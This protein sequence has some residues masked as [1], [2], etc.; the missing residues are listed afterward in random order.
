MQRQLTFSRRFL[1]GCRRLAS[2]KT[3]HTKR[4]AREARLLIPFFFFLL[5][6]SQIITALIGGRQKPGDLWPGS[7]VQKMNLL[8]GQ[9]LPNSWNFVSVRR[10]LTGKKSSNPPH[11]LKFRGFPLSLSATRTPI[12]E[13]LPVTF[14]RIDGESQPGT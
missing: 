10:R 6:F 1:I 8:T 9:I 5:C 13:F 3:S 14:F 12:I 4:S 7:P 11:L 2:R